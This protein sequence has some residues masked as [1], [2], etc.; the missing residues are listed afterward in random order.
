MK[1]PK[2]GQ[3]FLTRSEIAG[4]VAN[5]IDISDKDTVLEI[6]PGHGILTRE[7]LK[8][9]KTVVAIEKDTELVKELNEKFSSEIADTKLILIEEDVRD[10]NP[11]KHEHLQTNYNLCAN[12]PYYITGYIIRKFLTTKKQPESIAVLIQKEVAERIV[13]K[14]NKHSILSIS[15]YAYGIPKLEKIVKAG[16][17]SPPPKVDS[18]ILSIKNISHNNFKDME[19]E[20]HFFEVIKTAFSQKRKTLGATLKNTV[21]IDDFIRCKIDKKTRPEDVPLEK[22]LCISSLN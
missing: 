15:V 6:G 3:H 14:N 8:L 12:I 1:K 13:A 7:L 20:K 22:W 17:F 10:F 5:S 21:N 16:A 19:H 2:L 11:E 18:A 4:W 9:A